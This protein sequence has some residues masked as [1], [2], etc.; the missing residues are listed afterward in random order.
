[1]ANYIIIGGDGKEYGPVTDTDV[2]LWIAEGRLNALSRA[3]SESDA[4][5]RPLAAFPEFADALRTGAPPAIGPLKSS[6]SA[7]YLERD[8]E[9]DIIGCISRGWTLLTTHF[10]A[11][12]VG[13]LLYFLIEIGM[14]IFS[15]IPAIGF[16]FSLANFVIAGPL[17]AGLYYLAIRANRGEEAQAGDLFAGFTRKF[18]QLF[19][20]TLAQGILVGLC[21]LPFIVVLA[22]RLA[23]SLRQF[24]PQESMSV[25]KEIE[26]LKSL[27]PII[28]GTLPWLLV[29]A[30]P[31]TYIAVS[32]KF[33]LALIIDKQMDFGAAMKASWKMVG[34][35]WWQIFGLVVLISLLNIAGAMACFVG[36]LFTVPIGI[37]ALM[38]A[39]ETIF[40]EQKH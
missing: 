10:A 22:M 16:I 11:L 35:H 29:C 37:G 7:D 6:A 27:V 17:M 38:S 9:L 15:K 19:C 32:L 26:M 1:M 20:G 4:E 21:L 34:K 36:L 8:Y 13:T 39:Y 25:D 23:P 3:K 28:I 14:G 24:N 12:F 40:G 33:M 18:A 5:F 2:R 30:L 31:A